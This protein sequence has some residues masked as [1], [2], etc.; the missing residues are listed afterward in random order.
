LGLLS[1]PLLEVSAYEGI[2]PRKDYKPTVIWIHG[3]GYESYPLF[4]KKIERER[5][6]R[7]RLYTP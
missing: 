1:Y 3:D 5:R 7:K 2:G 4:F 6:E